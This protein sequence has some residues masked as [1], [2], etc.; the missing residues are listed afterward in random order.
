MIRRASTQT[1]GE[2]SGGQ[3]RENESEK[4]TEQ[5]QASGH[6]QQWH[7]NNGFD[8]G[9]NNG[10]FGFDGSTGAFPNIGLNGMVDYSQMM[11]LM[12][13]GIPNTLMGSFP[14]M[15]GKNE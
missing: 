5:Q 6:N 1:V 9:I 2:G 13:N 4:Q 3:E 7:A 8:Q 10:A 15:I 12:P 11:H 14:N